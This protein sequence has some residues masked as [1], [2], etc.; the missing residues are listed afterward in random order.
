MIACVLVPYFAAL[1]EQKA[2]ANSA[3]LILIEYRGSR[4]KV[5]ALS[6]T[7]ARMGVERGISLSR[8]RALCPQ[9]QLLSAR[10]EHYQQA[11][12]FLLTLLWE[13]TNRVEIDEAAYPHTLR[14][15]LDLGSLNAEGLRYLGGLIADRLHDRMRLRASIGIAHAKFVSAI[16][17]NQPGV[18]L[19]E[20][21][22][23]AA[24]IAP[25]P[26]DA[27]PL[28]ANQARK[29]YL[30]G[31]RT[32][33]DLAGLPRAS[34]LAQF[35]KPGGLLH[36]LA[37]GLDGRPV[38]PGRMPQKEAARQSFEPLDDRQALD[39]QIDALAADLAARL[40]ARHAA[41]HQLALTLS[42]ERGKPLTQEL[43]LFE[44]AT[45]RRAITEEAGK[46]LDRMKPDQ[47]VVEI[48]LCAAHLVPSLARQLD[49][50]SARP[51]H[52]QIIDV[53]QALAAQHPG[54]DFYQVQP[55]AADSLLP[56]RRFQLLRINA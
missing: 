28:E 29:L 38:K 22:A 46:L 54:V 19:V 6:E 8:A 2:Q 40:E 24:F 23:E 43:H 4:G 34:L 9:A 33:G 35:G 32:L 1:L 39:A 10:P 13:F 21:G 15:Y 3:P 31:I 44:P 5:I 14:A 27:L 30:L 56:E 7:A 25:H 48:E 12:D 11:R 37:S 51:L 16:A 49:L 17:A 20:R 55:A 52:Q 41:L 42:F 50:F 26:V 45:S 47:P 36:Q 18:T 53:T